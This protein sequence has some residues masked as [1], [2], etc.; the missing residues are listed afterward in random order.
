MVFYASVMVF[1]AD[2]RLRLFAYKTAPRCLGSP[3]E[4][5]MRPADGGGGNLLSPVISQTNCIIKGTNPA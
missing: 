5:V 1:Y 4:C 2:I 3:S